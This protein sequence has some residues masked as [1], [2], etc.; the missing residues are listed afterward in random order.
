MNMYFKKLSQWL[1][2][3]VVLCAAVIYVALPSKVGAASSK[4]YTVVRVEKAFDQA[5][6]FRHALDYTEAVRGDGAVLFSYT[7][8][9]GRT[10]YIAF[11]D[12]HG[13][14]VSDALRRKSTYPSRVP[15]MRIVRDPEKSCASP[16]DAGSKIF[17]D[18][19]EQIAGQRALRFKTNDGSGSVWTTWYLPDANCA[20]VQQRYEHGGGASVQEL[21]S[22]SA[23]EPDAAL[24]EIPADYQESLPSDLY[25]PQCRDGK[26]QEMPEIMKAR[27]NRSYLEVN[28]KR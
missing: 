9:N 23:A 5:G 21:V 27:I 28:Q 12:G 3:T 13:Y 25:P 18:G 1:V 14:W 8:P 19:E 17:P 10:R 15:G 2:L 6:T 4:T 26:C 16:I 20:L 7:N 11:P 22:F 24:F